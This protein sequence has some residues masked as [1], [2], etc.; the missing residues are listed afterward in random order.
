MESKISDNIEI[1]MDI[2][3]RA[4]TDFD[5]LLKNEQFWQKSIKILSRHEISETKNENAENVSK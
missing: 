5:I 4:C 2:T 1:K 3:S